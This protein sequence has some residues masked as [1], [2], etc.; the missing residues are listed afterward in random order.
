MIVFSSIADYFYFGIVPTLS[1][2]VGSL[3]I[4]SAAVIGT[5]VGRSPR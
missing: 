5:Q 4:V 1:L 2:V 3:A